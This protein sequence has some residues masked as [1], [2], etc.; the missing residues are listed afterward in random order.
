VQTTCPQC[1]QGIIID[2]A[3]IPDRP[4]SVKCPR[5][6]NTVRF[7]GRGAMA[8]DA[9]GGGTVAPPGPAA[10]VAEDEPRTTPPQ[11]SSPPPAGGP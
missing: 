11:P 9:E 3:K 8:A 10:D 4:F 2:D 7:P 1:S 6:K 5:C